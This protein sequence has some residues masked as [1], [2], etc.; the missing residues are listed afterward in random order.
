MSRRKPV[1]DLIR[2]GYRFADK[3]MRRQISRRPESGEDKRMR[4]RSWIAV[5]I[6]AAAVGL[7]GAAAAQTF[8]SRPI[9][10]I[11]TFPPG[12]S[13]DTMARALQPSLERSLG[14]PISDQN[15]VKLIIS[16]AIPA[17]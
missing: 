15:M 3:D 10:L 12:G 17:K 11:V 14:Q 4:L 16:W 5:A 7:A 8:P 1:P 2:D 6:A 13:T 9:R